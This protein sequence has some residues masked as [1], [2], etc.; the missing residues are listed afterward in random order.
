MSCKLVSCSP[1]VLRGLFTVWSLLSAKASMLGEN[2]SD[3]LSAPKAAAPTPT[4][5][6]TAVRRN[7]RRLRNRA[8]SSGDVISDEG[9]SDDLRISIIDLAEAPSSTY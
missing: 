1:E 5:P 6:E 9:M 3:S 8:Y 4:A 2:T 7:L